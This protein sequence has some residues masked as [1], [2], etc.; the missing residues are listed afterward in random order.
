M[1]ETS[2]PQNLNK[3][4]AAAKRIEEGVKTVIE[5]GTGKIIEERKD[6]VEEK[7]KNMFSKPVGKKDINDLTDQI[8]KLA[9]RFEGIDDRLDRLNKNRGRDNPTVGRSHP[10]PNYDP[11]WVN[12]NI[13]CFFT[14]K[15]RVII[16]I[17]IQIGM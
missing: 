4:I 2:N 10:R 9:L 14:V 5:R 15:E 8:A 3:E 1:A 11:N 12:D 6:E 16:Q 17:G 13:E 7:L